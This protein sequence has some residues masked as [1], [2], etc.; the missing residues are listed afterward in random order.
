[1]I[2]TFRRLATSHQTKLKKRN[3]E[4]INN[5]FFIDEALIKEKYGETQ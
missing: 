5:E 4:R 1:M 3:I 2:F